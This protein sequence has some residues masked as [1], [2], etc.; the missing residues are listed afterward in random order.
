MRQT[1]LL[2]RRGVGVGPLVTLRGQ[3]GGA[4]NK[5]GTVMELNP[6]R[7]EERCRL[8]LT[9]LVNLSSIMHLTKEI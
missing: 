9:K 6:E 2:K 8:K 5:F 4:G 3:G 7:E 1:P